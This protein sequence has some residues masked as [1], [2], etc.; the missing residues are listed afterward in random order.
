MP[1][2]KS[3]KFTSLLFNSPMVH[4]KQL[5]IFAPVLRQVAEKII[6]AN[7]YSM[8]IKFEKLRWLFFISSFPAFY[9]N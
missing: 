3:G 6:Y 8:S 5:L 9:S 1:A 7:I 4:T 2:L